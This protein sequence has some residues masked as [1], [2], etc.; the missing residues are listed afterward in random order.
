ML[1]IGKIL[2]RPEL[3][4]SKVEFYQEEFN[5]DGATIGKVSSLSNPNH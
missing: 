5:L 1:D 2:H 4:K 3:I